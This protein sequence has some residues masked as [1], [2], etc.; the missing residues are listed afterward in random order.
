M[1]EIEIKIKIDDRE[2]LIKKVESLG[3][4]KIIEDE[5]V[6]VDIMYDDKEHHFVAGNEKGK[7]LRL[8]QAP[9][10]NRLT[11]K[12]K[13]SDTDH[14]HL[15]QRKEI[16]VSVS[17]FEKTDLILKSLGFF[18]VAIKEKYVIDYKLDGFVLEFHRLP[19]LGD[20]L[21][22][23]GEE[24]ELENI[25][26]KLGLYMN[27]GINKGYFKIFSE[28]CEKNNLPKDTPCTFEKEKEI[29]QSK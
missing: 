28:Y 17:D 15:L 12:E 7:H 23:E 5:G 24:K 3:G 10:G 29:L 6:A 18:Q 19:F 22:I 11:Y 27:Q 14:E 26:T 13:L 21:E 8:R 16:E 2:V 1:Q 25:I 20:F 4:Q 9:Y